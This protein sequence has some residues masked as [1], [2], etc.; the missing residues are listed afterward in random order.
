MVDAKEPGYA[1]LL[2]YDKVR[3]SVA[4][5]LLDESA[6]QLVALGARQLRWYFAEPEAGVFAEELFRTEDKGRERI[7][8]RIL[9]W[10][11]ANKALFFS[12]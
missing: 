12:R 1:N 2:T 10:L 4:E 6:R 9:P 8:V 11:P 5:K 7:E 3:A